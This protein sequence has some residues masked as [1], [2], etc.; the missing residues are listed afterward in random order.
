MAS[1]GTAARSIS[2]VGIENTSAAQPAPISVRN[3]CR[4]R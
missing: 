4:S 2:S 1:S 3:S